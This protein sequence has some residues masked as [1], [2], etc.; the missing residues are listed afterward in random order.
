MTARIQ[1]ATHPH[2]YAHAHPIKLYLIRF[3]YI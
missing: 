3:N 2:T 1:P